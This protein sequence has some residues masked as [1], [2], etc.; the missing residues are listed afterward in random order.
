MMTSTMGR[1]PQ[2]DALGWFSPIVVIDANER[3]LNSSCLNVWVSESVSAST[4]LPVPKDTVPGTE[5]SQ[6]LGQQQ[7]TVQM[8]HDSRT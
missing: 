1:P 2:V 5:E 3:V 6:Q 7:A 4:I 8:K